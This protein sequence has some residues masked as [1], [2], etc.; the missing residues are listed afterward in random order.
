MPPGMQTGSEVAECCIA[1]TAE[2]YGMAT[3][4]NEAEDL[5]PPYETARKRPDW[6]RWEEAIKAELISLEKNG[7]WRLVECPANANVIG[8]KWILRIKKNSTGKIDKYK[9]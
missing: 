1:A 7:T 8:S 6:P 9:A 2:D 5:E 4:M 3:M